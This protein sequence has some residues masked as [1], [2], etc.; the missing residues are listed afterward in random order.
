[1][2]LEERS[3]DHRPNPARPHPCSAD[4]SMQVG[5]LEPREHRAGSSQSWLSRPQRPT[6]CGKED[7]SRGQSTHMDVG[8]ATSRQ[9][10][11]GADME[12]GFLMGTEDSRPAAHGGGVP[13]GGTWV[14]PA[15]HRQVDL[16]SATSRL[17]ACPHL[18]TFRAQ[19]PKGDM[20]RLWQRPWGDTPL[21][22]DAPNPA[23]CWG[24]T[25]LDPECGAYDPLS[26]TLGSGDPP[27][28]LVLEPILFPSLGGWVGRPQVQSPRPQPSCTVTQHR[29]VGLAAEQKGRAKLGVQ[30]G[31][32]EDQSPTWQLHLEANRGTDVIPHTL[33]LDGT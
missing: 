15:A 20:R 3:R 8:A 17:V 27:Q 32:Q 7:W 31:S 25:M 18:V 9:T 13:G 2:E 22:G 23:R 12:S 21:F 30:S 26:S 1:M 11:K 14:T 10:G 4:P 24:R 29:G 6:L 16:A 5:D 19:M 33:G 28:H